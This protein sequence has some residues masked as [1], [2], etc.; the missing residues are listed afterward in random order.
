ADAVVTDVVADYEGIR[1][2]DGQPAVGGIPDGTADDGAAAHRVAD[3]MEMQGIPAQHAFLAEMAELRV[4]ERAGRVPVKHRMA[5]L[6]LGIGRLDDDVAAQ[7]GDF[8]V[9]FAAAQVLVFERRVERNLRAV[10]ALD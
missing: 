2:V 4:A 6:P 10:D 1:T 9:E 7:V 3:E 8:A 5:A